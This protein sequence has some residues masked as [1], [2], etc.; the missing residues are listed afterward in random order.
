MN[1]HC[2]VCYR[3]GNKTRG[4]KGIALVNEKVTLIL[5]MRSRNYEQNNIY[6]QTQAYKIKKLL[7]IK[8]LYEI[9]DLLRYVLYNMRQRNS[10]PA[11]ML[12]R[13]LLK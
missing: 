10:D 5:P 11:I 4:N 13:F 3:K 9:P 6:K 2:L 12:A 8:F 7:A 1:I